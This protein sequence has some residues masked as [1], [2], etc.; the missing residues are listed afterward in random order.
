[1]SAEPTG[2]LNRQT[3]SAV[4]VLK[5]GA[6]VDAVKK[7]PSNGLVP[8]QYVGRAM[9]AI[10][11]SRATLDRESCLRRSQNWVTLVDATPSCC[12]KSPWGRGW[13]PRL[14]V[15]IKNIWNHHLVLQKN[16]RR[17][18][19]HRKKLKHNKVT[20]FYNASHGLMNHPNKK[21]SDFFIPGLT[22]TNLWWFQP[23]LKSQ[24]GNVIWW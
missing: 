19:G 8:E 18:V 10:I 22:P 3:L 5:T 2:L 14:G 6:T 15:E 23:I 24:N 7:V 11:F 20:I 1:M 21:N 13:P 9:L 16:S 17:A 12:S 4:F